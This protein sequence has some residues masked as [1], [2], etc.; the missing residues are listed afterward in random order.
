MTS[1]TQK[2]LFHVL[3]GNPDSTELAALTAVLTSL[4]AQQSAK[5]A[6]TRTER[7]MWGRPADRLQRTTLYN[8]NAFQNVTFY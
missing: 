8:P 7:N 6:D 5:A 1:P 4:A 3:K 2:P